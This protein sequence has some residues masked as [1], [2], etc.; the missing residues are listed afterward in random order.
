MDDGSIADQFHNRYYEAAIDSLFAMSWLGVRC[1]K[2]PG[3]LWVYQEILHELRPDFIVETGTY[4]GGSSWFLASVCDLLG[5]GHVLTV[6]IADMAST[7]TVR[8]SHPRITYLTGSSVSAAVCDSIRETIADAHTVMVILD[9][10]HSRE[11]V[12]KELQIYADFVT[13]DSYLVVEDT[14]VNGHPVHPS[15]GPGP[16]EAVEE[17]LREREDFVADRSREK[18]L[19]TANP[20]GFLRRTSAEG[21]RLRYLAADAHAQEVQ[22][23][24][25]RATARLAELEQVLLDRDVA[26][27]RLRAEIK[28]LREANTTM[29]RSRSWRITA[30]LRRRGGG[31]SDGG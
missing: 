5:H 8:P 7:E 11:H 30:P 25:D 4:W 17:F 31:S 9:S 26:D 6:D 21:H 16:W 18:F 23:E 13:E 12:F 10:D 20:R 2:Y 14:N 29:L 28:G 15:H 24:L 1:Q 3:D 27:A 19:I 22:A